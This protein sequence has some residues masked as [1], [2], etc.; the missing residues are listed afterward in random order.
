MEPI[1]IDHP[2][3]K[4]KL[5]VLRNE[6]TKSKE[7]REIVE[8]LT[9]ILMY[10]ATKDIPT[11]KYN[12]KTPLIDTEVEKIKASNLVIIPIIRAG[13][14]MLNGALK[15]IPGAR[16]GHLG[17]YRD[18][19]TL[20]PVSYYMKSPKLRKEDT[21]FIIDPMFATGGS[22]VMAIDYL[23]KNGAKKIKLLSIVSAPEGIEKL[24]KHH[25]DVKIIT[26]AIDSHLNKYGYIIPG[27]GDAGDRLYNIQ[28]EKEIK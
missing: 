21:I 6:D 14:G 3:V 17:I 25:P 18:E 15:L 19:K 13:L 4:H 5:G 23:K 27:L 8:E 26:C 9:I 2:L 28:P 10:E 1:I 11:I 12:V 22:M 16:V 24:N 20:Q 7:F